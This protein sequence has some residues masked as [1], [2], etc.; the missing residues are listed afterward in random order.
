MN[1]LDSVVLSGPRRLVEEVAAVALAVCPLSSYTRYPPLA[2]E[3]PAVVTTADG[4]IGEER[5]VVVEPGDGG[6]R[7]R[8][9]APAANA[10]RTAAPGCSNVGHRDRGLSEDDEGWLSGSRNPIPGEENVVLVLEGSE[11]TMSASLSTDSKAHDSSDSGMSTGS[12]LLE[13]LPP[14]DAQA[15]L[16]EGKNGNGTIKHGK[17]QPLGKRDPH[18]DT[19]ATTNGCPDRSDDHLQRS[20]SPDAPNGPVVTPTSSAS[21]GSE[22]LFS[23]TDSFSSR[24]SIDRFRVLRGV[25]RAFHSPAMTEAAAGVEL[26]A[27]K[28][29][30]REPFIPLASNVTGEIAQGG[31]MTASGYW[32]R[33]VLGTV[34]FY[35]GLKALTA[36]DGADD[37]S[38]AAASSITTFVE[39]GPSALLCGMGRRA[40]N[41][42]SE[43]TAARDSASVTPQERPGGNRD[44]AP[45]PRW[46]T[47]MSPAERSLGKKGIGH[48]VGAIRG[49]HYRR[50]RVCACIGACVWLL[51][52]EYTGATPLYLSV[53]YKGTDYSHVSSERSYL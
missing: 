36:R 21:N 42:I 44:L 34:R 17:G 16:S 41:P 29:S 9:D 14:S 7:G 46:I 3:D 10:T 40:I 6:D 37:D 2:E 26:A 12:V 49:V 53:V 48:V 51:T 47:T 5:T 11:S 45:S 32:S 39:V 1:G 31:L 27:S 4:K 50:R 38:L 33:H 20:P 23:T 30:L 15:V 35:D 19:C 52:L 8:Y 25:S 43:R 28:L 18:I 24:L 22:G 13:V